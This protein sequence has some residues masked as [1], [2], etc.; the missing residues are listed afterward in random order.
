[1]QNVDNGVSITGLLTNRNLDQGVED[2]VM[3]RVS[4]SAR[5]TRPDL[6]LRRAKHL[7][8]FE[9]CL[10]AEFGAGSPAFR[11]FRAAIP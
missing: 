11:M 7:H 4:N 8:S 2:S 6:S 9:D 10:R 1:M 5:F 3:L